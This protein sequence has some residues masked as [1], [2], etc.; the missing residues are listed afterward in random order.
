MKYIHECL[1][2]HCLVECCI[3]YAYLWN[4]WEK[5]SNSIYALEVSRVVERSKVVTS[6]ECLDNLWSEDN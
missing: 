2:W 1:L 3:E 6:L 5:S 4:L